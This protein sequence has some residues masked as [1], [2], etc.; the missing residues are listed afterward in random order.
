MALGLLYACTSDDEAD[1]SARP[2][3]KD[4]E[5]RRLSPAPSKRTEVTAT[6][7]DV[8]IF[9]MG[10]FSEAGDTVSDVEVYETETDSW[11]SGP[12][13]PIAVN[14]AMSATLDRTVYSIGGY[15]GP[16]LQ[17]PTDRAFAFRNGRWDEIPPMPQV[18]A[19]G[20][21]AALDGAIYVAGGVGPDGLAEETFV[22]DPVA[23][24]WTTAHGAPTAREHLG[25]AAHR[26][27]LYVVGGR[28]GGIGS[29]LAATEVFDPVTEEWTKLRDMPTARGGIGAAATSNGYVLA[30]GGEADST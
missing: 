1:V 8:R 7:L 26:G 13:L 16:G 25:V 15:L 5:W 10:G 29:N 3:V 14:H 22:F 9:V 24:Q 2:E 18:R 17:N 6:A 21:A 4:V 20:G 28:T 19:A 23:N 30:A 27:L 11:G 12:D